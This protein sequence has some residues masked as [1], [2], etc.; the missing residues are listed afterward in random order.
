MK[1]PPSKLA[2]VPLTDMPPLVPGGTRLKVVISLGEVSITE[3]NSDAKVSPQQHDIEAMAAREE[4]V[5]R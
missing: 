2:R 4:Y 5:R 3:P 1:R